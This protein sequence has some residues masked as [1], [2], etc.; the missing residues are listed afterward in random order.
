MPWPGPQL[1]HILLLLILA[2]LGPP[3]ALTE[4]NVGCLFS[5]R[6]CREDEWCHNDLA[7]GQC[8][9]ADG[10]YDEDGLY[11]YSLSEDSLHDLSKELRRLFAL[12]YRWGHSYTQCRLQE[13]LYSLKNRLD[14]DLDAC[15]DLSDN[16]LEG[17]LRALEGQEQLDPQQVAIIKYT[18]SVDNPHA[19]FADEVYYPPETTVGQREQLRKLSGMGQGVDLLDM[20]D[21][22]VEYAVNKRNFMRP[23]RRRRTVA[24]FFDGRYGVPKYR[25]APNPP[26]D[27]MEFLHEYEN[28]QSADQFQGSD[29]ENDLQN[30]REEEIYPLIKALNHLKVPQREV[31]QYLS[32]SNNRKLSKMLQN[33]EDS[34][35]NPEEDLPES[36]IY[37]GDEEDV[38]DHE[39]YGSGVP[40]EIFTERKLEFLSPRNEVFR[41]LKQKQQKEDESFNRK[42]K[43]M[44]YSEGGA[45]PE[46]FNDLGDDEDTTRE[47]EFALR[48]DLSIWDRYNSMMGFKRPERLDVKKPGPPFDAALNAKPYKIPN[49]DGL[50]PSMMKKEPRTGVNPNP[51]GPMVIDKNNGQYVHVEF[52]ENLENWG[53]G[54]QIIKFIANLLRIEAKNFP[55]GAV[56]RN[57]VSFRVVPSNSHGYN[58]SDVAKRLEEVKGQLETGIDRHVVSIGIGNQLQMQDVFFTT[59][60]SQNNQF[61][62]ISLVCGVLVALIVATIILTLVRRHLKSKEKL[63][64]LAK[65][66]TEASKDYQDLCRARMA[67]K[68]QTVEGAH[69]KGRI[70]SLSRESEQSPSS[71]S[72]TSSWSEEPALHNMDISTGHMVLSYM[73]DHLKNKDRLEQEWVALCAYVAEPC[74]TSVALKKENQGRNRYPEVVPYDHA[75]VILNELSNANGSDYINASSITDHDPRNPAYIATQGPLPH[76]APDFWQLIWEQ[77]AVV[78]VMLT[79]LTE[80]GTAMCHRYWPEEG[81]EV[82]HIYEVHLVS[83]HIWCDDYLV[84]SFYLKNV[85]TGETRTV[86]QFHFLSWPDGGIPGSTKALLEFRRK[87]NKS[88]RGRSC[89]IVVH[90]SDGAGRTGTYC[91]IDMVLSRMAKGA[92]EIDIAATLE[93]LRDQR[94]RMVASK[95][96][97]EFV[98]TA[99]AEEVHAILKAL[100]PQPSPV[101][102]TGQ[103]AEK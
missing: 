39:E 45:E 36:R 76:T 54:K 5:E 81:S 35:L 71:R 78:I 88:Y 15:S 2:V 10:Y 55:E 80:G 73:E 41:E 21:P 50:R 49:I 91:L 8:V 46:Q 9:P 85:K 53:Q 52:K 95:Q 99:V 6:I 70:T 68:G 22:M 97:F 4:T 13:M 47:R 92:K 57:S 63:Q 38:M 103:G 27:S 56:H 62:V 17:A 31:E 51:A 14:F 64:G 1:R 34:P 69:D 42:W 77:G 94:S 29:G 84:R 25:R 66:D 101:V 100:P 24:P 59:S 33:L 61:I 3:G 26:V 28:D 30:F 48:D 40:E 102:T 86:T 65:P 7:F 90:C 72:S 37:Y 16:D 67:A 23:M 43:P 74:D 96:Q 11:R 18:P 75:R 83:E 82:Y 79:R 98:L 19:S 12:G 87:V 32:P 44:L 58:A 60:T 89:P 20:P 93:H